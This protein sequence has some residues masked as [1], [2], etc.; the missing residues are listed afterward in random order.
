MVGRAVGLVAAGLLAACTTAVVNYT[1]PLGPR[2]AGGTAAA[3]R[4]ADTLKVVAFN[5]QYA[6]HVELAIS[7]IRTTDALRDPDILLLQEMD[8][9]GARTIADSLGL[10]WVYYPAT[11]SPT[12]HRDFG[13]AILSRFPIEDDR[14]II[15]PHLARNRRT[16]RAAVA[17]TIRVEGR[18]VRV[19][20]VHLATMFELGPRARREQLA[21]VLADA[22]RY[23]LV[24]LGGDF[25]SSSVP[26]IARADGYAWPTDHLGR[27]EAFW[28]MDHVLL[29]GME[30]AGNPAVGL[31]KNVRGAS[32]HKPVWAR[33][34]LPAETGP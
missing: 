27:T 33:V 20:S 30:A 21:A 11:V 29:K 19:Y 23:P 18:Q 31:V 28:D 1:D 26:Q 22:R 4:P 14:K 8:E 25:N 34:V 5:I 6:R 9:P 16:Q 10:A 15:L 32:D 13:D 3:P 24:V 12:T 17:A 2:Y 7:L